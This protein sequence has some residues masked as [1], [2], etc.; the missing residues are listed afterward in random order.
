M[1]VANISSL[2]DLCVAKMDVGRNGVEGWLKLKDTI[3]VKARAVTPSSPITLSQCCAT[4]CLAA[5]D[6]FVMLSALLHGSNMVAAKLFLWSRVVH[7]N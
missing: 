3:E 5:V 1:V 2:M 4:F 6:M 7:H